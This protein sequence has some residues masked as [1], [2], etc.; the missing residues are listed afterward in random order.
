MCGCFGTEMERQLTI[1]DLKS[2]RNVPE[3]F[4]KDY[5]QECELIKMMTEKD[6]NERPS[7]KQILKSNLFVELGKILNK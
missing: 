1:K 3:R 4:L 7:A 6:Y 2:K 5:P